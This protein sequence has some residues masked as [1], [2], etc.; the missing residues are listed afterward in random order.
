MYLAYFLIISAALL[1]SGRLSDVV[2]RKRVYLAGLPLFIL[3]G[4]LA[5]L[6]P[7]LVRMMVAKAVQGIGTGAMT[8]NTMAITLPTNGV[9]RRY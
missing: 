2:G 5:S 1:P 7:S 9:H 3:G 4:A 6:S 8:A